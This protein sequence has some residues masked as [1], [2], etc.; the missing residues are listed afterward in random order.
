[1][2]VHNSVV[3]NFAE[4][5]ATGR[6]EIIVVLGGFLEAV[7]V[8]VFWFAFG[9]VL[10][11]ALNRLSFARLG[12]ERR[13]LNYEIDEIK[14][15][16]RDA[17]GAELSLPWS[18]VLNAVFTNRLLILQIKPQGSRFLPLRAFQPSELKQL[19]DMTMRIR[20]HP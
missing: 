20:K 6:S 9:V 13:T 2:V 15:V 3:H 7:L 19:R 8:G 18:N 1:M 17:L 11:A 16:I 5:Q 12:T 10:W 14:I 4:A